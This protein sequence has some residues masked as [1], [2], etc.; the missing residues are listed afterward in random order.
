MHC[1]A[2]LKC[3]WRKGRVCRFCLARHQELQKLLDI[4]ICVERTSAVHKSHLEAYALGPA[5]NKPLHGISGASPLHVLSNF[6]VTDQ[7]PPDA[8]EG[9]VAY[10]L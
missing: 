2:G 9:G 10:I 8:M 3:N 6:E 7:L 1:L 4:E 5:V